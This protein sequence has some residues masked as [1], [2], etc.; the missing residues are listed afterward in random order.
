L[1]FSFSNGKLLTYILPCFPP[2]AILMAFGLMHVLDEGEK[3]LFQWGVA[4][5][6][7]FFGLM[8]LALMYVQ[9][10]GYQGFRPYSQLWKVIMAVSSGV[11]AILFCFW[12]FKNQEGRKKAVL[13]ALSPFLL[14]FA[15][16]FIVPDLT[17]EMK[18]PGP[19]LERHKQGIG[20]DDVIISDED[21]IRAVCWY[22]KRSDVYV[23]G[24]AGELDYGLS[25]KDAVSRLLDMKSAVGLI[26]RNR[27]KIV[28]IA[29][30]KNIS[31]WQNELPKPVFQDD[32][33]PE[34]YVFWR[35]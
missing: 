1:F 4:G 22:L 35:Y 15:S 14:F 23:L 16:H 19:F 3:K 20:D 6:G 8:L 34:G 30:A 9:L 32:S 5:T 28:L 21:T 26:N 12:A 27:G 11:F 2:F 17:I 29:R 13:F 31:R 33:G 7:M 24:G 10:F 18:A 25:Y